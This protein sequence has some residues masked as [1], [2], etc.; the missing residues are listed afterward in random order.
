VTDSPARF[1]VYFAPPA[2][3]GQWRL[4][5]RWLGRDCES[6][7][8]LEPPALDGWSAADRNRSRRGGRRQDSDLMVKFNQEEA[9]Y[10]LSMTLS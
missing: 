8:V 10:G 1:A 9:E 6:G 7:A 4:A 3:G 5:Q 2:A